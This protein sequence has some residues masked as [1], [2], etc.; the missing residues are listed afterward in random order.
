MMVGEFCPPLYPLK[1]M[2]GRLTKAE[3]VKIDD[4]IRWHKIELAQGRW[5]SKEFVENLE[6][7]RRE[8]VEEVERERQNGIPF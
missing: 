5:Q 4:A 3:W 8:W 2:K 1:T 6:M 7:H